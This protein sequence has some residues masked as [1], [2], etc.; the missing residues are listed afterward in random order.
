MKRRIFLVCLFYCFFR[1]Q[2]Y[3]AILAI[4]WQ[5]ASYVLFYFQNVELYCGAVFTTRRGALEKCLF[6]SILFNEFVAE[7]EILKKIGSCWI[8]KKN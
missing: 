6:E 7:N 5:S 8:V 3:K 2:I 1:L 4:F